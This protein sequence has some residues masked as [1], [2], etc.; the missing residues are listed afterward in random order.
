[1]IA[2]K[3]MEAW[4]KAAARGRQLCIKRKAWVRIEERLEELGM[5]LAHQFVVAY[6]DQVQKRREIEIEI[7]LKGTPRAGDDIAQWAAHRVMNGSR[8]LLPNW[9]KTPGELG[10]FSPPERPK[11][12]GDS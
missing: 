3:D 11:T 2:R 6:F 7:P 10:N 9:W 5:A 12:G 4:L 1:M 8:A